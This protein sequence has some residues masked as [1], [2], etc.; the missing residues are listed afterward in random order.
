LGV[1]VYHGITNNPQ[2][3]LAI[4]LAGKCFLLMSSKGKEASLEQA[5]VRSVENKAIS[6]ND[7]PG[8]GSEARTSKLRQSDSERNGHHGR[9]AGKTPNSRR[10][11]ILKR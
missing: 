4:L 8:L 9:L 5:S 2:N 10:V 1:S 3:F 7:T 6:M 11:F